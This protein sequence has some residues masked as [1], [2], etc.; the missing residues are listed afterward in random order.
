[1]NNPDWSETLGV[2]LKVVA[3]FDCVYL[4]LCKSIFH[5]AA[6]PEPA[7]YSDFETSCSGSPVPT[8]LRA[9]EGMLSYAVVICLPPGPS[10]AR[11]G[12]CWARARSQKR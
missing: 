12:G 2:T 1:M 4:L 8:C 9:G 10:L 5:V 6:F 3:N 11:A 7:N